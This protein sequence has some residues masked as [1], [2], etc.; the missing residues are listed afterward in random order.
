VPHQSSLRRSP[1]TIDYPDRR[2][3]VQYASRRFLGACQHA[4]AS[5]VHGCW[6]DGAE[7]NCE[8]ALGFMPFR[9]RWHVHGI[10]CSKVHD[11]PQAIAN[12]IKEEVDTRLAQLY[13]N[14]QGEQWPLNQRLYAN[15]M[16]VK[17]VE[18]QE[19]LDWIEYIFKTVNYWEPLYEVYLRPENLL[20]DGRLHPSVDRILLE[21][22]RF[23]R[24]WMD[25]AF[26]TKDLTMRNQDGTRRLSRSYLW[27]CLTGR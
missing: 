26:S 21:E 24:E 7:Q 15:V 10:A 4:I 13:H 23:M 16:V 2:N 1:L 12:R 19:L 18:H 14:C 5:L 25:G 6:L 8:V 17:F 11:D 27:G 22:V 3:P 20:S 9:V